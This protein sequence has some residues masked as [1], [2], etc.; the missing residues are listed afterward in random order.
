MLL[1]RYPELHFR[2]LWEGVEHPFSLKKKNA[3]RKEK[4]LHAEDGIDAEMER[5]HKELHLSDIEILYIYGL[6]LG[7][8]FDR[9][10]SWLEENPRRKLVFLEDDIAVIDVCQKFGRDDLFTHPQVFVRFIPHSRAWIP[11]L[12]QC[13]REF[14]TTRLDFKAIESYAKDKKKRRLSQLKLKL[15]RFSGLLHVYF[16]EA[17]R[18]HEIHCNL[19]ENL[20]HFT[21]AF[22]ARGLKGAFQGVPAIICG[23]GPSLHQHLKGVASLQDRALILAGGS[24]ITALGNLGIFPHLA[25]AIDPNR[26]EV[27][28]FEA[29]VV[30]EVP[31]IFG[32]RIH[33]E[34]FGTFN[35]PLGFLPTNTGGSAESWLQKQLELG[36]ETVGE[37]MGPEAISVTTLSVAL[38]YVMGCDP[39]VFVGV[40]LAYTGLKRYAPGIM[41][42]K[43][44]D[45]Q[46]LSIPREQLDVMLK[47][48]DAKRQ[49]DFYPCQVGN[50][51]QCLFPICQTKS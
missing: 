9:L 46:T 7:Y 31:F 42:Q 21:A 28:R 38:A 39:I 40:D 22:D 10:R 2:L 35:A 6:G 34:V 25:I 33:P 4:L 37:E 8:H 17:I 14:P 13:A 5:F 18:A 50:G 30:Q 47:R 3:H 1:E 23:A 32:N 36:P 20:E 12:K 15:L 16:S 26:E 24:T 45:P 19:L 11:M 41:E 44:V 43:N 29:S 51:S 49:S 27:D 48:K